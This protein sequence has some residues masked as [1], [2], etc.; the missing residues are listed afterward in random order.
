MLRTYGGSHKIYVRLLVY[1][2]VIGEKDA[3][4][5]GEV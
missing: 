3:E 5:V 2:S 1:G 4:D